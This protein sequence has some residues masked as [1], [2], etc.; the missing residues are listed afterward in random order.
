MSYS[1]VA[2]RDLFNEANF[3]KCI[4]QITL[5]I[6]DKNLTGLVF[7]EV[8]YALNGVEFV[9]LMDSGDLSTSESLLFELTKVAGTEEFKAISRLVK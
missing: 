5:L 4:G 8:A 1:R 6:L 2:P 7:D 9:L 3:M